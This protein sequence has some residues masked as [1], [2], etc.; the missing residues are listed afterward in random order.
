MNKDKLQIGTCSWKYDSWQGIVYPERGPFNHLEE[1]SRHFRTVGVDLWFW[2]LFPGDKVV[3]PKASV[4]FEY[5]ESVP[6]DFTFSIKVPTSTTLTHYY[7]KGKPDPLTP[8]S[9]YLV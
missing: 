1:C 9:H 8:N 3:F 4:I 5:A 7:K 2:S 6:K